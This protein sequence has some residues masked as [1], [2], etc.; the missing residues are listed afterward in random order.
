MEYAY[1]KPGYW[2]ASKLRM[3]F[4]K[5]HIINFQTNFYKTDVERDW[6]YIA[7]RE[8]TYTVLMKSVFYSLFT[9]NL[10]LSQQIFVRK[11]MVFWPLLLAPVAFPVYKSYFLFKVNKR[12]FDMCN[13][14]EEYQLGEHRNKVLQKCN[15]LQDVEDF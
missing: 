5:D 7:K 15:E 13:V 14:G 2:E 8:Y 12:L 11:R 9:A 1:S 3:K 4:F 6:A 10:L